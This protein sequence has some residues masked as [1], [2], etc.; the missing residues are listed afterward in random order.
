VFSGFVER[1]E[2]LTTNILGWKAGA[3]A[4][5]IG[6]SVL[7]GGCAP[8][9][10]Q[11]Y[12]VRTNEVVFVVQEGSSYSLGDCKRAADGNLSDCKLHEVEFE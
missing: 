2:T 12:A 1:G 10:L 3:F 8:R 6:L 5:V 4:A 9:L 11:D 7:S